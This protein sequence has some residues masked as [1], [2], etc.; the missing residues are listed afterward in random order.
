M[1][2]LLS[3]VYTPDPEWPL[4]RS[5]LVLLYMPLLP[6]SMVS[7]D[8]YLK[9]AAAAAAAAAAEQHTCMRHTAAMDVSTSGEQVR[10][11]SSFC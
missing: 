7:V 1:Y 4:H 5:R 9:A 3:G 6:A 10:S 2:L 11:S 8:E